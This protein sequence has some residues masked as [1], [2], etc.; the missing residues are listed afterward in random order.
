MEPPQSE[1][2]TV[3]DAE[4][5]TLADEFGPTRAAQVLAQ[6]AAQQA[7]DLQV[8]AIRA[9]DQYLTARCLRPRRE[10]R[11]LFRCLCHEHTKG[12]THGLV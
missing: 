1:P 7:H 11:R 5:K 6:L 10:R 8:F 3:S 2:L 4:L 9:C 12:L